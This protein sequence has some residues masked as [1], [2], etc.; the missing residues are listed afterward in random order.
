MHYSK[1]AV[2]RFE[3]ISHIDSIPNAKHE[4]KRLSLLSSSSL[5]D[6][7]KQLLDKAWVNLGQH[8][9]NPW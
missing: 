8:D 5:F 2:K 9:S 6:A 1:N 4:I 3:M 7:A